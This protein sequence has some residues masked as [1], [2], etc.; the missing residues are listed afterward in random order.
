MFVGL[1]IKNPS[2][3]EPDDTWQLNKPVP[4]AKSKLAELYGIAVTMLADAIVNQ[5]VD[6]KVPNSGRK[7]LMIIDDGAEYDIGLASPREIPEPNIKRAVRQFVTNPKARKT[8]ILIVLALTDAAS[9][10]LQS[11]LGGGAAVFDVEIRRL[12]LDLKNTIAKVRRE[13][14][15]ASKDR[16]HGSVFDD[17]GDTWDQ[18]KAGTLGT[19]KC[20]ALTFDKKT[21]QWIAENA[22]QHPLWCWREAAQMWLRDKQQKTLILIR[23]ADS[24]KAA[25]YYELVE[26]CC[27]KLGWKVRKQGT[28]ERIRLELL[29]ELSPGERREVLSIVDQFDNQKKYASETPRTS[30]EQI[31]PWSLQCVREALLD[32]RRSG[33]ST[34]AVYMISPDCSTSVRMTTIETVVSDCPIPG[35][36]MVKLKAAYDEK[37]NERYFLL[38]FNPPGFSFHSIHKNEIEH[39]TPGES[40][41]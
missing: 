38:I 1:M 6:F 17:W 36:I 31:Q 35:D 41:I 9:S 11:R 25:C 8:N 22:L 39:W 12:K 33:G 10:M 15:T 19:C 2:G 29:E 21:I 18:A 37:G 5:N 32:V 24:E 40:A 30:D 34:E 14:S 23:Y 26:A 3:N 20:G 13:T 16:E 28:S 4:V 7:A 27:A